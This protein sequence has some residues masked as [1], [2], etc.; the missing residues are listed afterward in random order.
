[1]I[2]GLIIISSFVVVAVY[3]SYRYLRWARWID[4]VN[5]DHFKYL[6]N[7]PIEGIDYYVAKFE[8]LEKE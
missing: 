2:G 7:M 6:K 1:M 5:E 4:E 8:R 3:A